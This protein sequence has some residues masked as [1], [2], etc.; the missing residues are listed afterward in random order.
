MASITIIKTPQ[1]PDPEIRRLQLIGLVLPL[2]SDD[3]LKLAH[4]IIPTE[5]T[6]IVFTEDV[7]RKLKK[8]N[9]E[10]AVEYWST[11]SEKFMVFKADD[12]QFIS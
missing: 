6:F 11:K 12:C 1:G 3:I 9:K 10:S 8:A 2:P 5:N 7:I 4:N